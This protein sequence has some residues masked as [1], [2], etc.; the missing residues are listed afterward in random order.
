LSIVGR[1]PNLKSPVA[2][3][4]TALGLDAGEFAK[5]VGCGKSTI[6]HVE[7]GSRPLKAE[8][9]Y[10][11]HLATGV[12]LDAFEQKTL[13]LRAVEQWVAAR[14]PSGVGLSIFPREDMLLVEAAFYAL[15][16]RNLNPALVL[17]AVARSVN[18]TISRF[19]LDPKR[20]EELSHQLY[21]H[22]YATGYKKVPL[23][24]NEKHPGL[25]AVRFHFQEIEERLSTTMAERGAREHGRELEALRRASLTGK[26]RPRRKTLKRR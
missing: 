13:P 2:V 20:V 6:Q 3:I 12:P 24:T 9:V 17:L 1:K 5:L 16:L 21:R 26:P 18:E 15:Q 11:I 4:R 23:E 22:Y 10:Q 14:G 19:G 8:L 25:A 7:T